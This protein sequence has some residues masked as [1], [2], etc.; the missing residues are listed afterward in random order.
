[1]ALYASIILD[2]PSPEID[3]IFDYEIPFELL[4][5]V[6]SGAR[7]RVP[8]GGRN[9][10]VKGYCLEVK[11][12][13]DIPAGKIKMIREAPDKEPVLGKDMLLL[14]KW[15][16][17]R[18][19]TTLSQCLRIMLPAGID[20]KNSEKTAFLKFERAEAEEEAKRLSSKKSLSA[21][22][23]A[24]NYILENG[25]APVSKIIKELNISLSPLST[26]QKRGVIGIEHKLIRHEFKDISIDQ[27]ET[28]PVLNS[29]Q[30]IAVDTVTESFGKN[31]KPFLLFGITG[32][33]KTEVYLKIIE[34]VLS[35]GKQAIVLVP[36]ISLTPLIVGRFKSRFGDLVGVTHSRMSAGERNEVWKRA[37][38]G[39]IS[40]VIGP[41]SALFMPFKSLGII[42]ID[43]EH[44]ASYHS[45]SSPRYNA[46]EV[47]QKRC[48]LSGA[49][50]LL[51]S[52]TPS[53]ES[54][55]KAQN[56]EYRL[57]RLY[58][59]AGNAKL[60]EA[61]IVDMR[62][63]LSSGNRSIFSRRLYSAVKEKLAKNEQIMLFLNRRGYSTFVSCRKCG[64][65]AT[66]SNC[67]VAYKYHYKG[68]FLMC[69]YCGQKAEVPKVCPSCGSK[70]IKYFG[71]GTQKIE[72]EVKK[73][74]PQSRVLRMDFDTTSQKGS[75]SRI[76]NA[77]AK[78]E[79]DILIGTQM[80]AKGHDFQ[81]VSLVGIMAA[82]V[83]LNT[84][85]YRGGE[86][87]FELIT[88]AAGRAGRGTTVG[89][90]IIQTYQPENYAV[91]CAA[92]Q[93]YEEF[94][95]NEC[96]IRKTMGY[97]PFSTV[98]TVIFTGKDENKVSEKTTD[99]CSIL[100]K[101]KKN[102]GI[103]DNI[104]VIGPSE[105][106]VYKVKNEYR[107][108]LVLKCADENVLRDLTGKCL[109][110]YR[111]KNKK[112]DVMVNLYLSAQNIF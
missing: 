106:S 92:R 78:G 61:E 35:D 80:I 16:K 46:V 104:S 21:Q 13:S 2:N 101:L 55:Y 1:M 50:L 62:L 100:Y 65:V 31:I 112:T 76:L 10:I 54:F 53:V 89:N 18:Y 108:L 56:G 22:A 107:M 42:I 95:K 86:T 90:V 43:E 93:N 94:Y 47:A 75:H 110:E 40:V 17:E 45:D 19:F 68:N 60:P 109:E 29:S 3:R 28:V 41:R 102:N 48:N 83:S 81:N 66:C 85:D 72:E 82:D 91:K 49:S 14:A 36:E 74:F 103:Y 37:E 71:T 39:E 59:R 5:R 98:F 64:Y 44:E 79:A 26:L 51:G 77:F 105:A 73:L 97:P 7:V 70:Y 8:F 33:G 63:E 11:E 20:I 34:R 6:F 84:G 111:Q 96:S 88:Q 58:E 25:S 9:N 38:S 27:R 67:S 30:K 15:M 99:F 4:D 24:L 23:L 52:A 32:S 12:N 57:L 87:T 69:H